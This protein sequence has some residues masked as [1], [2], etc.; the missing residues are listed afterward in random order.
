MLV[1]RQIHWDGDSW[2]D[3]GTNLYGCLKQLYLLKKKHRSLKVLLSVGGWVS[4]R[5]N[6]SY[7]SDLLSH[8]EPHLSGIH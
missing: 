1:Q 5:R 3:P 2:N 8:L 4:H 7:E 6:R